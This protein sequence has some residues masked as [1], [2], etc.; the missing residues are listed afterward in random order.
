MP[1]APSTL[2]R[3]EQRRILAVTSEDPEDLRVYWSS[4][5]GRPGQGPDCPLLRA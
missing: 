3:D 4:D 2:T 1:M 5:I